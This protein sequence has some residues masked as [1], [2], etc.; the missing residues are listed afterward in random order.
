MN[1]LLLSVVVAISPMQAQAQPGKEAKGEMRKIEGEWSTVY[2]E[3]DGKKVDG[4]DFTSVTIKNSVVTCKHE[5]KEKSWK[6]SFGP[7]HMVRATELNGTNQ[8][9]ANDKNHTHHGVYIASQEFLCFSFN[10][11]MDRRP[12]VAAQQGRDN[13]AQQ[14]GGF[15][16]QQQASGSDLVIILRRAGNAAS[17]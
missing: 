8:T 6:L 11:G 10:K 2:V 3:M 15:D 17:E 5:G 14:V 13:Q 1:Y 4:K 9:G 7:H 16:N 12:G